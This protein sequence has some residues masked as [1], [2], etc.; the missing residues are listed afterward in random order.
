MK[1]LVQNLALIGCSFLFIF[2]CIE[3][4]LRF[5]PVN[6]GLSFQDVNAEQP[7]F[8][9]APNKNFVYSKNPDFALATKGQTNAQGFIHQEDYIVD[10]QQPLLALFG[11]SYVEALMVP[12]EDAITGRLT[13]RYHDKARVYS[14]AFSGA[15]L[16]QYLVWASHA[17]DTYKPDYAAFII[18][19]NDFDESLLKYK[20]GP[21]FHHFDKD[22]NLQRVDYTPNPLTYLVRHSAVLQYLIYNVKI[23]NFPQQ[24]QARFMAQPTT[25]QY[26]NNVASSASTVRL[27]DSKYAVQLFL[28]KVE[29]A[30]G[31]P[32]NKIIFIV[33]GLR[34]NIYS[35][36]VDTSSYV[37]KMFKN[38]VNIAKERQ[39]PVIDM[40]PIFEADYAQYQKWF[41]F[42]VD[43]HW[44]GYAHGLAADA[45]A[46]H[47]SQKGFPEAQ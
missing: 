38:F 46:D 30:T 24:I 20:Q 23:L 39:F 11:D 47:L 10:S 13:K 33:D 7:I 5:L 41:Q 2:V 14:F 35:G 4:G 32:K 27:Q 42:K 44:N 40:H 12:F 29:E 21:G 43:A 28:D 16:S 3:I 19:G 22:D 36:K 18:I 26:V 31:L 37:A 1:R 17:R 34:G 45:L 8:K 15:P 9:A 6:T 25:T